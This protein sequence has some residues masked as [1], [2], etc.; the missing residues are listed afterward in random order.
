MK[1]LRV[2]LLMAGTW[3]LCGGASAQFSISRVRPSSV[4]AKKWVDTIKRNTDYSNDFFSRAKWQAERRALRKE[5]NTIEFGSTLQ[6]SQTQFENWAAGGD[7]TFSGRATLNFR[8]QYKRDKFSVDYKFNARYGINIISG[9]TFKNEDQFTVNVLTGWNFHKNWSYAASA[10]LQSQFSAGYKSRTDK[11][12]KSSFMAPGILDIS[13]G[14]T[15]NRSPFN[16]VISPVGGRATFVLD[17]R[18]LDLGLNGVE[19]G[20]YSKWQVGPSIRINFDKEF[21]KKVFRFRSEIYSFTNIKLP[22]TIRW[23][24]T[25]DIRAT[26]F[27]TTTVYAYLY[28][29]KYANTPKPD[30]MQY[31]YSFSVG[32]SYTFKNK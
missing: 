13:V 7:N 11:T 16:I 19:K 10:N 15:Y 31:K 24:S 27:L 30:A 28:Y 5:R 25:L 29:D 14:V 18:L 20:R 26:K 22:P 3:I 2:L 8:H 1:V 32:L 4:E 21:L 12:L 6:V 17:D 23:E 9:K